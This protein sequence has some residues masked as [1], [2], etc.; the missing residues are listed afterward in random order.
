MD[1]YNIGIE[2]SV[3]SSIFFDPSLFEEI[4]TKLKSSDF[5][6]PAHRDIFRVFEDLNAKDTPI[7]EDFVKKELEREKK[8]NEEMLLEVI[9]TSPISNT[10]AYIKEIKDNAIRRELSSLALEIKHLGDNSQID[11]DQ[12]IDTIQSKLYLISQDSSISDFQDSLEVSTKT[13][14]YIKQMKLKGNSYLIGL[15]TGFKDLNKQTTGFGKGDLIILAARPSMGKTAI[16]LNMVL[17]NLENDKGVVFFSLE[18]P[19]HQLM[20]RLLSAKTSI[21]L[22]KLR[23]GDLDDSEWSRLNDA[24]DDISKK[25]LFVDDDSLLNI[26]QIKSK[27]RKLKSQHP[28]IDLIV[29]DYLQ[30]M[31]GTGSKDRHLEVSEISRG[32]KLLARELDVPIIALSQLNRGV[33]SRPDKRPM[34][35]DL[36]E[37]GSIEQDAD[38][39]MFVYR[40]DVYKLKEERDKEAQAKKEGVEYKKNFISKQDEDAELIIGKQRNGPI[41][42]VHL[43]F[44]KRFTRFVDK[45]SIEIDY[46][47]QETQMPNFDELNTKVEVDIV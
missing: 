46:K 25:K 21:E 20:L 4:S 13:L 42:T 5:Y 6:Y 1:T 29:I 45:N 10:L 41:G 15:D 17:R 28:D 27:L 19:S 35:S 38:I 18:M 40:D 26:N 2:R 37:S 23:V 22:Q 12:V 8:F 30:L 24:L 16:A 9:A 7:D 31:M 32:L 34:L 36:R 39:I 33:D 43:V 3:L 44:H 11:I 47:P 14:Q